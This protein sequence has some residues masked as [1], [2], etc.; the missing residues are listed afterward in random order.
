MSIETTFNSK[1]SE[2][3]T[4]ECEN[5]EENPI[6]QRIAA[7]KKQLDIE[8]KVK[9]GAETLLTT[10]SGQ[11]KESSRKMCDEAQILLKDA[12]AKVEYIRLEMKRLENELQSANEKKSTTHNEQSLWPSRTNNSTI[13]TSFS[14]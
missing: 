13:R 2:K 8:L 4:I 7:L 5:D 3:A 1:R 10:Y 14:H 6:E 9:A 11:R 12:K